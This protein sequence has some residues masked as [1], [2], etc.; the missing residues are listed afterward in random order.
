VRGHSDPSATLS[1]SGG[2]G[3]T[4]LGAVCGADDSMDVSP[5]RMRMKRESVGAST[6]EDE[7]GSSCKGHEHGNIDGLS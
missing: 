5:V 3:V 4:E 2:Q 7:G 6:R 1:F